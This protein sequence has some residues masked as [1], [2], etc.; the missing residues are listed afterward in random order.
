MRSGTMT[1]PEM[2]DPISN[3]TS[4]G[5]WIAVLV[6]TVDSMG[7]DSGPL[8]MRAG[9]DPQRLTSPDTRF[10]VPQVLEMWDL[11]IE[12]TGDPLIGLAVARRVKPTT[13]HALGYALMACSSL[14][15]MLHWIM[16]YSKLVSEGGE[17]SLTFEQDVCFIELQA[18]TPL[19]RHVAAVDALMYTIVRACRLLLGPEVQP[20]EI[21]LRRSPPGD[22]APF[23]R[24]FQA[25]LCFGKTANRIVFDASVLDRPA[26]LANPE[27]ARVSESLAAAYLA[28]LDREDICNRVRRLLIEMLPQGEPS[29]ASVAQA[30]A[31][32]ERSLQRSIA[33]AG[34]SFRGLLDQT[35]REQ[36][37]M[38]LRADQYAINTVA[39]M[40]GFV[41]MSSFTRA[42]RRWMGCSPSEWRARRG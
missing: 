27:L 36:A 13:F 23:E 18:L 4:L 1:N 9:L 17:I 2:Q 19:H 10:P 16:R 15:E 40:L 39:H 41:E 29:Q 14:R 31:M 32:S 37:C 3:A 35:R 5:S 28:R 38:L 34:A 24:A 7:V 33:D 25:T 26:L 6:E 30:L 21:W 42:F 20:K 12:A 8:L 11:A 22:L